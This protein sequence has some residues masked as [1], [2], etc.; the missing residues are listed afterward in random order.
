MT[1]Y[2]CEMYNC[3]S[4][5]VTLVGIFSTLSKAQRQATLWLQKQGKIIEPIYDPNY[6]IIHYRIDGYKYFT[7]YFN[8]F[9][10]DKFSD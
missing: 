2:T 4:L 3:S 10:V 9:Q 5:K 1:V 8:P 6:E 7:A